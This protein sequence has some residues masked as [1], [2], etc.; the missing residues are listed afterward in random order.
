MYVVKCQVLIIRILLVIK[1]FKQLIGRL[2]IT[3]A[4]DVN[5]CFVT[6]RR[7]SVSQWC[8]SCQQQAGSAHDYKV[9]RQ[10]SLAASFQ[11]FLLL[12]PAS[13]IQY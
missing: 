2:L 10:V 9:Y 1:V 12:L 3:A 6:G 13:V 5:C 7:A 11:A 8:E 4:A